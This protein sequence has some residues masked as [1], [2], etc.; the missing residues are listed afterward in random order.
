MAHDPKKVPDPSEG[1]PR[2]HY[3]ERT[4][5]V[6]SERTL[7]PRYPG[8][9]DQTKALRILERAFPESYRGRRP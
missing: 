1:C 3:F 7:A 5:T 4:E 6:R 2:C 9:I 8:G